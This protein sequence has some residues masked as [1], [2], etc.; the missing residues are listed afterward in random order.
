MGD[1]SQ[2]VQ[3]LYTAMIE[4]VSGKGQTA[5]VITAAVRQWPRV[6]PSLFLEQL[7]QSRWMS[8][9]DAWKECIIKYGLALTEFQRAERLVGFSGDQIKVSNSESSASF[10]AWQ[11]ASWPNQGR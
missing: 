6:S 8:L 4:C 10:G 2:Y 3:D 11:R 7:N 1:C 9:T 5:H